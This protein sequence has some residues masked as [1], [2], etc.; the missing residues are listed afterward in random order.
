MLAYPLGISSQVLEPP[1]S[2]PPSLAQP[3]PWGPTICHAYTRGLDS[4]APISG[5]G[6]S[7]GRGRGAA[8]V[9]GAGSEEQ[10]AKSADRSFLSSSAFLISVP[11][12]AGPSP[13]TTSQVCGFIWGPGKGALSLGNT[14]FPCHCPGPV[15]QPFPEGGGLFRV[16]ALNL[17][18]EP[19]NAGESRSGQRVPDPLKS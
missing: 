8:L 6:L 4:Q 19:L 9:P 2:S 16:W 3:C 1:F 15:P 7:Q 14:L 13:P 17:D 11:P 10:P 12:A 5:P 18:G